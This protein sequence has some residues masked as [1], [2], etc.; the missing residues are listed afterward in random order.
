MQPVMLYARDG[1]F[2]V[3]GLVPP[4]LLGKEADVLLWGDKVF[5]LD[6]NS[7]GKAAVNREFDNALIYTEAFAIALVVING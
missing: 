6:R 3:S 4:F 5:T 1:G 2:V 7:D